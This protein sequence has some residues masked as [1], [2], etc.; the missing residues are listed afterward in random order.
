MKGDY[1]ED[2]PNGYAHPG[3]HEG[4]AAA[5]LPST[6]GSERRPRYEEDASY[7]ANY[8]PD[9][10]KAPCRTG[11]Q[12]KQPHTEAHGRRVAPLPI[13]VVDAAGN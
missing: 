8:E 4:C 7:S 12:R 1:A 5:T 10:T 3:G 11:S 2:E 6:V 9:L 13:R